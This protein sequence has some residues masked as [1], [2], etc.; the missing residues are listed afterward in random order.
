MI[1]ASVNLLFPFIYLGLS[2]RWTWKRQPSPH[3]F[4]EP[5]LHIFWPVIRLDKSLYSGLHSNTDIP[6]EREEVEK[7]KGG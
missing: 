2:H 3:V 1:A 7:K 5:P 4:S 6:K